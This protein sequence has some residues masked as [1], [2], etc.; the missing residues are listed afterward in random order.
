[1]Q[2]GV[3]EPV[4]TNAQHIAYESS[5]KFSVKLDGI[6]RPTEQLGFPVP[7]QRLLNVLGGDEWIGVPPQFVPL[8]IRRVDASNKIYGGCPSPGAWPG[9]WTPFAICVAVK[10]GDFKMSSGDVSAFRAITMSPLETDRSPGHRCLPLVA[11][12]SWTRHWR[13]GWS[14]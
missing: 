13:E 10:S 7:T 2:N 8:P 12:A 3:C 1:M 6:Y 14:S 4:G 9:F 5:N 11:P